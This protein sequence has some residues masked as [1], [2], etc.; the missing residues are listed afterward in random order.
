MQPVVAAVQQPGHL[1]HRAADAVRL[2]KRCV[3]CGQ[4][5]SI[6]VGTSV[7]CTRRAMALSYP[8][9]VLLSSWLTHLRTVLPSLK[10]YMYTCKL[11]LTCSIVVVTT[12]R[13]TSSAQD[14]DM[15]WIRS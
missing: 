1:T 5:G 4:L 11:W 7:A 8:G 15:F 14:F 10:Q 12:Y 6:K 13:L 9:V 3:G 2:E